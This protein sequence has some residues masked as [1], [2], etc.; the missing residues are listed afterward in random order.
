MQQED[1]TVHVHQRT[2]VPLTR[3]RQRNP[4][5]WK[6]NIRKN[7]RQSGERY[8]NSRGNEQAARSVKTKK[9]CTKCKFR[10]SSNVTVEDRSAIFNEFWKMSDNEKLH[11]YGKTT[12][13]ESTK[14][15][16][17][18]TSRKKNNVSYSLPVNAQNVPVCKVFYLTTLDINHKRIQF[19]HANKQKMCGTPTNL[20]W[21][22]SANNVV[23]PEIKD[24]I[25]KHINSLPRVES[26]YNRENTKKE[27]LA[28]GLNVRILYEEYVKQCSNNGVAPGKIHLYRQIFNDEF[29]IAF[30]VPK[31]DRCD[32]CEAMKIQ[33]NPAEED[34]QNFV[35]HLRGKEETKIERDNDRKD[36]NKFTICFDLQNVF[37]LPTA[38]VSNFFYK[39]KLNVYFMTA[40]CS[41]DKRGYGALWHEGQSGRTGNDIASSVLKILE[42]VVQENSE[43]PRV[44]NITLWSDSCVPQNRNSFFSTAIKVFLKNHP[45]IVS[46]EHKYCE[47]GHSSVQEVDNLH[48]QIEAVCRHTEI[49]SPVGLMRMLKKVHRS[50]PMK[51]I[52]M[53][54]Q[55][56]KDFGSIARQGKYDRVP[57]T[58]VKSLLYKQV[59]P[60]QVGYRT[61]LATGP[62]FQKNWLRRMCWSTSRQEA[63]SRA[64]FSIK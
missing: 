5:S 35:A 16:K 21:G 41:A 37:A 38:E 20:Q 28:E 47:P 49:Y 11:F 50:K 31:K 7:K 17:A 9:D 26:H 8:I 48:S 55:D 14:S 63:R 44:K 3:K 46:I 36:N 22:K 56:F 40:H 42:A 45:E 53:K 51:I 54:S 62:S 57:F 23:S 27:Y 2:G 32:T 64:M 43:D 58:K 60:D 18:G 19:Y 4:A 61:K 33:N 1:R 29:N 59:E 30:H 13:Q 12:E 34:K 6:R 39:R 52:Q 25:R 24:R 15:S 10:C